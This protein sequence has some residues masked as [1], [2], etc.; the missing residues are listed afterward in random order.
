MGREELVNRA[1]HRV[2]SGRPAK[3][4]AAHAPDP[5]ERRPRAGG[6]GEGF[7]GET[8]AA[9]VVIG[10]P[11][12]EDRHRIAAQVETGSRFNPGVEEFAAPLSDNV[13]GAEQ[14]P[15]RLVDSAL[16]LGAVS[17][18]LRLDTDP[19]RSTSEGEAKLQAPDIARLSTGICRPMPD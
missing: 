1:Q 13:V 9:P 11:A 19:L 2:D 4:P 8:D 7:P 12:L 18:T 15:C 3:L 6:D 16:H 10:A 14:V 17:G 5:D